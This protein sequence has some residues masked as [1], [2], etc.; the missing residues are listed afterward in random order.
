MFTVLPHPDFPYLGRSRVPAGR[1][2]DEEF[3]AAACRGNNFRRRGIPR[4]AI[5]AP[6]GRFQ[7]K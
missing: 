6:A 7:S 4:K 5:K 3:N 2:D 1:C